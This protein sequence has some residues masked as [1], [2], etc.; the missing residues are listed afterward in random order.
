MTLKLPGNAPE[1]ISDQMLYNVHPHVY[2]R[3]TATGGFPSDDRMATHDPVRG[4][5]PIP[6]FM[7]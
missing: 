5:S 6:H 3:I 2:T 1:L 7:Q 4:E